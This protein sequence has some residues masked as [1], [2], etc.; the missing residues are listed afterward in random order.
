MSDVSVDSGRP[1]RRSR[2]VAGLLTILAVVL[3]LG[4]VATRCVPHPVGPARTYGKYEGKAV[5]TAKSARSDVATVRLGARAGGA[6]R[7]FGPYLSVLI[8]DVEDALNA[9]QSTFDSIQPPSDQGDEL[10][11]ELDQLLSDALDHVRDVRMVVRRGQLA[12][13]DKQSQALDEDADKLE[14]FTERHT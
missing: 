13:L 6:G 4:L 8:S 5:T 3:F 10:Q 2:P 9:A 7:A 12:D 11:Q 1:V 14:S